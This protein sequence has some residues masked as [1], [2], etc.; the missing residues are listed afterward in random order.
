[1]N[2][3]VFSDSH[4]N[5]APMIEAIRRETPD[6]ILHLGDHDRDTQAL[7]TEFP[8]IPFRVVRGNCDLGSRNP[9]LD[10]FELQGQRI[11]MTHGHVQ[12]VKFGYAALLDMGYGAGA[13]ILLFGHTHVPYYEIA[14]NMHVINP[15][16]AG[17]GRQKSCALLRLTIEGVTCQ[18]LSL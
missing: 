12:N 15:G 5:T 4:G 1:M 7:T 13:D 16:S 18:H 17:T 6:L 2:I 14:A 8:P 10:T 11:V 3:L 9:V